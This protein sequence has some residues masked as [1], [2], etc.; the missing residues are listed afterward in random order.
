L[1]ASTPIIEPFRIHS[2]EPIRFTTY[3]EREAAL[4]QAGYNPF[5]L[6]VADMLMDLLTDSGASAVKDITHNLPS[7]KRPLPDSKRSCNNDDRHLVDNCHLAMT[8]AHSRASCATT[9]RICP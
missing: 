2:V 6:H 7:P 8:H 5:L 4:T 9:Q 1:T 3:E